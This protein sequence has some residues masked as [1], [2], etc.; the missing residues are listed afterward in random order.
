MSEKQEWQRSPSEQRKKPLKNKFS[1]I[2]GLV[3][4]LKKKSFKDFA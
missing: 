2:I 1:F 3:A 4:H